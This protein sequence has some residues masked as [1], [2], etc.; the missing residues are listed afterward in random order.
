M[1]Y[2]N[3]LIQTRIPQDLLDRMEACQ[4]QQQQTRSDFI[5]TAIE[6]QILYCEK[7][8]EVLSL[9]EASKILLI[10]A[11]LFVEKFSEETS[12]R[13]AILSLKT[14][15]NKQEISHEHQKQTSQRRKN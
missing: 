1:S 15:L 3:F 6:K 5:R 8:T 12:D 14:I 13:E 2:Q 4:K 10:L 11:D 7:S 9:E